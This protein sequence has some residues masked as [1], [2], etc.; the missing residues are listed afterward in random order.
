MRPTIRLGTNHRN[1]VKTQ[2]ALT[3]LNRSQFR[4]IMKISCG[5][6]VVPKISGALNSFLNDLLSLYNTYTLYNSNCTFKRWTTVG[7]SNE[8]GESVRWVRC[9][10]RC[11]GV[12]ENEAKERMRQMNEA[13][14]CRRECR[15]Y[16]R[17]WRRTLT[18]TLGVLVLKWAQ[19]LNFLINNWLAPPDS[20]VRL[21]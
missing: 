2:T 3:R 9:S 15:V 1:P 7:E 17:L 5:F 8:S 12:T 10:V 18:G 14:E 11:N 6:H 13:N 16:R 21:V 4:L 20:S 19:Q